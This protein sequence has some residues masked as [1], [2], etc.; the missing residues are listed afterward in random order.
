ML[1]NPGATALDDDAK[2][3]DEEYSGNNTN[4]HYV[5]HFDLLSFSFRNG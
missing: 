2:H 4:D 1:P 3:D 5:V